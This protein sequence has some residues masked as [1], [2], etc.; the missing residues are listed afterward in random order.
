MGGFVILLKDYENESKVVYRYGPKEHI[1]GKIE[2]NKE[3]K[4][5]SEIEPIVDE[6]HS[7]NFYFDRAAQRMARCLIREGGIFPEKMTFDS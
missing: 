2:L 1:M 7:N 3:T 6:N 5:F 4:M